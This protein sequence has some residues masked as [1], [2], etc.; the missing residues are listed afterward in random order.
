MWISNVISLEITFLMLFQRPLW[1]WK[2]L[3]SSWRI[4]C[5]SQQQLSAKAASDNPCFTVLELTSEKKK[6]KSFYILFLSPE[7]KSRSHWNAHGRSEGVKREGQLLWPLRP[8]TELYLGLQ[9]CN[10]T[11]WHEMW[12]G[13]H[14]NSSVC[15]SVSTVVAEW[16]TISSLCGVTPRVY[17]ATFFSGHKSE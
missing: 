8:Q 6:K 13:K 1:T 12:V 14:R 9:C 15:F 10:S 5:I 11:G 4:S 16:D 2:L 7:S 3:G 17:R